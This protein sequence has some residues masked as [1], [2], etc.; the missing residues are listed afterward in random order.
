MIVKTGIKNIKIFSELILTKLFNN[1]S[2]ENIREVS[3]ILQKYNLD[4][5]D[6][7]SNRRE[8]TNLEMMTKLMGL[9]TGKLK[10]KI[11]GNLK[12]EYNSVIRS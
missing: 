8:M 4:I 7:T 9:R 1:P 6:P 2:K 12:R 5:P 3:R 10:S 11:E